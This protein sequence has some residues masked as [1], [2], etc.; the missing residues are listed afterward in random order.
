MIDTIL[1]FVNVLLS[2]GS[3]IWEAFKAVKKFFKK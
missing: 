2:S 3:A 1:K